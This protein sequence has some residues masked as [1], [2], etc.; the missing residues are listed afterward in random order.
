MLTRSPR[1]VLGFLPTKSPAT[2]CCSCSRSHDCGN[3]VAVHAPL[4]KTGG[5]TLIFYCRCVAGEQLLSRHHGTSWRVSGCCSRQCCGSAGKSSGTSVGEEKVVLPP[6]V[7]G[8]LTLRKLCV[9][10]QIRC[11]KL[12]Y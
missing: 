5:E 10:C 11:G 8:G 2:I 3:M 12:R 4:C 9:Q 6:L 1:C 7:D